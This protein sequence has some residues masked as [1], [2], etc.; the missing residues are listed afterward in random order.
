MTEH[1]CSSVGGGDD[2]QDCSKVRILVCMLQNCTLTKLLVNILDDLEL[3][4]HN[5][6]T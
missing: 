2:V 1:V 6:L 5:S 4:R 3:T